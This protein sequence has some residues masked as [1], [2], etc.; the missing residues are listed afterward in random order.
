VLAVIDRDLGPRL[1]LL[2]IPVVFVAIGGGGLLGMASSRRRERADAGALA[3]DEFVDRERGIR[4]GGTPASVRIA[5]EALAAASYLP[6]IPGGGG[7]MTL[8][9]ESSPLGR[10][11]GM[12]VVALFWNGIVSVFVWQDVKSFQSGSPEWG[13]TLFL[14][15]FVAIGLALVFGVFWSLLALANPRATLKLRSACVPL[16]GDL[17]LTWELSGRTHIVER[18]TIHL[19]GV[20]EVTYR[21]GTNT[22]TERNTFRKIEIV[23]T[24]DRRELEQGREKV[25]VPANVVHSFEAPNNK[26]T[27]SLVLNGEIRRWP[28]VS[29]RYPVVVVPPELLGADRS[30]S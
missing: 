8:K 15:P 18:L 25:R 12:T 20:E 22:S 30:E 6:R 24:T 14:V 11:I 28:D 1:L 3:R 17:E 27:W 4:P 29:E 16:G 7:A 26:V 5:P 21:R 19:E 9:P 13:L 10:L 23:N 2:L